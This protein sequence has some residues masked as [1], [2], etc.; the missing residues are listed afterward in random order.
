V[1]AL[2]KRSR[3]IAV[4]RRRMMNVIMVALA[5]ERPAR[6]AVVPLCPRRAPAFS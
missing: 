3:K 4:I 1:I 2:T 5:G 6:A